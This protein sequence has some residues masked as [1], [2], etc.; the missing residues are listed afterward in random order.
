MPNSHAPV[1]EEW[2]QFCEKNIPHADDL[3]LIGHSLGCIEALRFLERNEVKNV[4]LILVSG[5]DVTVDTLPQSSAFTNIPIDYKKILNKIKS[6]VVISAF[7]DDIV[8]F[9]Y[10]QKLACH[11]KCKLVMMPEGKHF[12][13]RDGISELPIVFNELMTILK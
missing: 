11:L 3:T 2:H 9:K 1:P 7:D 12:I 8:P 13:D 5:F 10:S 4:N 6:A